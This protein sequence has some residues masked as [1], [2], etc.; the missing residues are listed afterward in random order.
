MQQESAVLASAGLPGDIA[1]AWRNAQPAISGDFARDARAFSAF[2][3]EGAELRAKLP[4]KS[5]RNAAQAAASKL[6][7]EAERTAREQFLAA[8]VESVYGKLTHDYRNFV[9]A[10]K[11]VYDAAKSFPGLT[12]AREVVAR[13]D[14]KML[15][16][17]DGFEI[18]QGIFLSRVLGHPVAGWHLLHAM[19]LPRAETTE[20]LQHFLKRGEIDLGAARVSRMGKA[21]VLEMHNP[22]FL[23]AMD[24]STSDPIEIATDLAILDPETMIAVLRGGVVENPKYAGKRLFSAGINLTLLYQGKISFLFYI[25]HLLGFENKWLR[26]LAKPDFSPDE[27]VGQTIEKPWIAAV[28]GF[29]IGGGCQHLLVMDYILAASD[30]YMTLPARKEGIIPGASNMRLPRFVGDRIARQ[31]IMYGRRLDCDSPEG[32]LICDEIAPP[33]QMDAALARVV[34]GLTSAGVVSAVANRRGFRVPQE[35]I[36][37]FLNYASVYAREQAY[38][39]FSPALIANLE[40]NWNAQ[41][42][43]V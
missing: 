10:E 8:H 19:L 14:R 5:R 1:D 4:E 26:G 32:R 39:H 25:R 21:S 16:E 2:W 43:K 22:R 24:D 23:N 35:P 37:M 6:I 30:A 28:D 31:A 12:P 29:A 18:D 38:C 13:D 15:S 36:D 34:E 42:R 17:K 41:S 9:R 40:R 3:L 7:F 27:R 33:D 20:H 11:L